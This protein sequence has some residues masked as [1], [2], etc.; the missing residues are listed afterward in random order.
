MIS[1]GEIWTV[2][3]SV[4]I[5]Y[6]FCVCY[7]QQNANFCQ[8]PNGQDHH[9]RG[10]L[11]LLSAKLR[12]LYGCSESVQ[13]PFNIFCHL[14]V[15][16]MTWLELQRWSSKSQILELRC[17]NSSISECPILRIQWKL[18]HSRT[19]G[20]KLCLMTKLTLIKTPSRGLKYCLLVMLRQVVK[21][22]MWPVCEKPD[23]IFDYSDFM[24]AKWTYLLSYCTLLKSHWS[25][26]EQWSYRW[27]TRLYQVHT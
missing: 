6:N 24:C 27:L 15:K 14:F 18:R 12:H 13:C 3:Q 23:C 25:G 5:L 2:K 11:L 17:H 4:P 1:V 10:L 8:D 20:L 26:T 16:D 7:L 22:P 21:K 19:P 9:P